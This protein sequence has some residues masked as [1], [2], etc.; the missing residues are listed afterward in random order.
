MGSGMVIGCES[1][2][3]E[4]FIKHLPFNDLRF[5]VNF[6]FGKPVPAYSYIFHEYVNNFMGNQNGT[7]IALDLEANPDN[8][9]FR[10]AYSFAAGDML[11]VTL[12]DAGTIHWDWGTEWTV[13]PPNQA[14]VKALIKNLNPWRT[15]AAKDFLR[16]GRMTAPVPI[17]N[18]GSFRLTLKKA[19]GKELVFP[20]ILTS[21][22]QSPDGRQ[23]QIAVNF[24]NKPQKFK[25]QT[26]KD[27]RLYAAPN[28]RGEFVKSGAEIEISPLSAVLTEFLE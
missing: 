8:L 7:G 17:E 18:G 24:L 1:A 13:A 15:G 19:K 2:A 23:A 22:W 11:T 25:L 21:N 10:I 9:L 27:V 5:N 4:P 12:A 3:A 14:N 6:F 28:A 20:S 16:F 26:D